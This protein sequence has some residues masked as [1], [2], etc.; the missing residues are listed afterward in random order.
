MV[1]VSFG[2][3]SSALSDRREFP[4]FFRTAAPDSS[5]NRAR[6]AL[7]RAFGWD[8]VAALSQHQ[9]VFSLAVNDLVTQLEQANVT[10]AATVTFSE[11]DVEDQLRALRDMDTRIIIGSFSPEMAPKI[12]CEAHRLGMFGPDYAWLVPGGPDAAWWRARGPRGA[13]AA[14]AASA[15]STASA[16]AAGAGAGP[17]CEPRHLAAA[18]QGLLLVSGHTRAAGG[19]PPAA[20]L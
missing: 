5:H 14:A 3:T 2:A 8:T 17:G 1:E 7:V 6:L 19:A 16:G 10:C 15:S 11:A 4:L 18:V 13:T 9:D 20:G 12:F